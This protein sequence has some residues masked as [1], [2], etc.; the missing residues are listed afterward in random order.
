MF[1]VGGILLAIPFAAIMDYIYKES[2]LVSL[3]E[4]KARREEWYS[5]ENEKKEEKTDQ[6][7]GEEDASEEEDT[8]VEE[9]DVDD[10]EAEDAEAEDVGDPE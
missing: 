2:I 6:I 4:R 5:A 3:A 10:V 8:D 7:D 1:G 9:A